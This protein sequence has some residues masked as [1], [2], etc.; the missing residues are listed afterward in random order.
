[1]PDPWLRRPWRLRPNRVSRFYR[2]GLLLDRFRRDPDARDAD[3]PEDWLGSA[4]RAWTPPGA[5]VTEEGLGHAE[6]DGAVRLV[7]DVLDSNPSGISG[8]DPVD[9]DEPGQATTGI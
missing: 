9:G 7:R 2:G 5:P 6:L 3:R 8:R 4:T 1:M